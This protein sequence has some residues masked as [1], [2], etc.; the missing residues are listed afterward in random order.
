MKWVSW[1]QMLDFFQYNENIL[2]EGPVVWCVGAR[3]PTEG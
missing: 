1:K 3:V 2:P